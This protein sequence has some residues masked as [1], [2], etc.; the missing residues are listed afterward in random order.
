MFDHPKNIAVPQAKLID[1]TSWVFS[2]NRF[3]GSNLAS[4]IYF[5]RLEF[6]GKMQVKKMLLLK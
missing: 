3:N 4:G 1:E 2:L 6:D 5:S